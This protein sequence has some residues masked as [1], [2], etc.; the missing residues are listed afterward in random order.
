MEL[1]PTL[2][3]IEELQP[4]LVRTIHVNCCRRNCRYNSIMQ[5]NASHIIDLHDKQA[6]EVSLIE[7]IQRKTIS[8]LD[9]AAA[10]KAYVSDFGC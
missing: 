2:K 10:F 3:Y 9:E 7:N 4:I 8:P 6:F 1:C 5:K